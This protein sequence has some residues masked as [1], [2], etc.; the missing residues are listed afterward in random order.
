[1]KTTIEVNGHEIIIEEID[2]V[3]SVSALKDGDVIEEFEITTDESS[4]TDEDESFPGKEE[5]QD[6]EE[7][8][9]E[10]EDENEEDGSMSMK[11]DDM[12]EEE[13]EMEE[14]D[15]SEERKLESFN[16]FLKKRK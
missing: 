9:E 2:G 15:E 6:F 13:E 1:M 12:E 14:E 8:E 5:V 16:S 10:D 3:I 7:F 11:E 4:N